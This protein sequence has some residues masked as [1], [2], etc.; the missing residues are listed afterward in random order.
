M[1]LT[2][3]Q[4]RTWHLLR[5]PGPDTGYSAPTTGDFQIQVVTRDLNI[6]FADFLSQTGIAPGLVERQDT[7]PVFPLLDHPVP[8]G[9]Q[10]I[11]RI[12]YTPAGQSTYTLEG[13]SFQEFDSYT[14]GWTSNVTGGNPTVYRQPFAGYIRLQPQ[15]GPANAVGPGIGYITFSGVPSVG[16]QI[17]VTLTNPPASPVT[18]PAYTVTASDTLSSVAFNV[19]TL[20]NNSA[21][22]VGMSAFLSTTGTSQ[23]QIQL[24]AINAPGTQ[25]TFAVTLTGST[26]IVNPVGVTS[27]SPTGDTMTWYYT[28]TGNLL[29]NPGDTPAIPPQF[30]MALVYRVLADYYLIKQDFNQGAMYTKKFE[31]A[32]AKGK[33]YT[34]DSNRATQPTIASEEDASAYS[35]AGGS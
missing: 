22:V 4:N 32:V 17:V 21:A 29:V 25:I 16:Q 31:L 23:N 8:P 18:V 20:M 5:E 14:G 11:A 7:F 30:H 12:E 2:D 1:S 26:M 35:L 24:N 10:S 33:A 28:A 15:P 3:L 9:L 27:L 13:K 6:A 34:F 19:S